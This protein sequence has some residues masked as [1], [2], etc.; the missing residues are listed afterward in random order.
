MRAS[1]DAA[2]PAPFFP[3]RGLISL[4]IPTP[5]CAAPRRR[6]GWGAREFHERCD[7]SGPCV[8]IGRTSSGRRFGAFS[9]IAWMSSDDYREK[10]DDFLFA[11]PAGSAG[12]AQPE[13][14]LKIGGPGPLFDWARGGPQ[15]GAEALAVGPPASP[16]GGGIAGPGAEDTGW[17]DL[18]TA[19]SRLGRDYALSPDGEA[20]L[21]G[22]PTAELVEFEVYYSPE[23]KLMYD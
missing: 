17:G 23:L 6:D 22:E 12:D 11:W 15:W 21:F 2:A 3:L 19:R 20:S 4:P 18:R 14:V 16:A 5:S 10:A 13:R 1:S 7:L 9:P 8:V